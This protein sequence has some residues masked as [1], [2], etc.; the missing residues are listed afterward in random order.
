[1]GPLIQLWYPMAVL[2]QDKANMGQLLPA[3]KDI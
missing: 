1:M 3:K 2:M